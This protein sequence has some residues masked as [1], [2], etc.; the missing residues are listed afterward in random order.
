MVCEA[1]LVTGTRKIILWFLERINLI[2]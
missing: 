2:D 1:R